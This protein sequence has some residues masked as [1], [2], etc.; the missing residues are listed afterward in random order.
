MSREQKKVNGFQKG[1]NLKRK[2][3]V[4]IAVLLPVIVILILFQT[5][6]LS[7]YIIISES[8]DPTLQVGDCVILSSLRKNVPQRGEIIALRNPSNTEEILVKRVIGVPGD[9][10]LIRNGFLYV[11]GKAEAGE[12]LCP[13]L[14]NVKFYQVQVGSNEVFVL[15]DNRNDS[16][17]SLDFGMVPQNLILGRVIFRYWPLLRVGFITR[18]C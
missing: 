1:K 3:W 16:Y 18:K 2:L 7:A 9:R 13:I 17:D 6:Y 12:Q 5:G 11:N 10:I 8:M 4:N 14:L 15:G